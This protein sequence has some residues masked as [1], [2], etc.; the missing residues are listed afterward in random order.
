MR[1]EG[2]VFRVSVCVDGL[3]RLLCELLGSGDFA[4][5]LLSIRDHQL[6][7]L[8]VRKAKVCPKGET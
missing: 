2:G 1:E 7:P 3:P 4:Y 8:E 5:L 6:E